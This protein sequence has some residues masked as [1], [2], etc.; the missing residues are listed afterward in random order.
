MTQLLCAPCAR[1]LVLRLLGQSVERTPQTEL[2]DLD[3]VT[4]TQ[5]PLQKTNDGAVA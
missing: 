5:Q 4:S 2:D 3:T 1:E